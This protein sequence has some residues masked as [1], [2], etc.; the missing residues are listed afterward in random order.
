M[1]NT[2]LKEMRRDLNDL[3]RVV[4]ELR[5]E[6]K[7]EKDRTKLILDGYEKDG[8]HLKESIDSKFD[9]L[10]TRLDAKVADFESRFEKASAQGSRIERNLESAEGAG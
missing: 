3:T 5:T 9:V 7:H 8:Q 1:T 6:V 2:E 4:S 10:V